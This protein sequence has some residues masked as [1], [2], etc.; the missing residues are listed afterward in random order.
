M[1]RRSMFALYPLPRGG[2]GLRP[3]EPHFGHPTAPDHQKLL[4][5][6]LI[7]ELSTDEYSKGASATPEAPRQLVQPLRRDAGSPVD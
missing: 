7:I 2:L 5:C 4:K 6:R 1:A 3:D